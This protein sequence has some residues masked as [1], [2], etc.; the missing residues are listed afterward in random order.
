MPLSIL[1]TILPKKPAFF[2][3]LCATTKAIIMLLLRHG[4]ELQG[5]GRRY[6]D[7]KGLRQVGVVTE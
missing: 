4:A 2:E 7:S 6:R 3:F 1:Y 5:C